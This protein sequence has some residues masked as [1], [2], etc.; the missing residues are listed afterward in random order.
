[1][2]VTASVGFAAGAASFFLPKRW[3]IAAA[4]D[5]GAY[6]VFSG[7]ASRGGMGGRQSLLLRRETGFAGR[8]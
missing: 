5:V 7:C 3:F 2:L 8:Q 6:C 4:D 1:M